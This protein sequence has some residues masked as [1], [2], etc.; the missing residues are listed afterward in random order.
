MSTLVSAVHSE[1]EF[2]KVDAEHRNVFG[3]AYVAV[4]PDG[5]QKYDT[6]GDFIDSD[7]ELERAG[8]DFV[9]TSRRGDTMHIKKDTATLIESIVFTKEK[10]KEMGITGAP[11]LGWWVGFH[12]HNDAVWELVKS[13]KLRGFSMGGRGRREEID[14]A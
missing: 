14:V 1:V 4:D 12:V 8:Y 3:W 10:A 5:I 2:T 11:Q 9:I 7:Q 6:Q 13:G